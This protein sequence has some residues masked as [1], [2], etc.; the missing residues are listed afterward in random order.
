MKRK[1]KK[2]AWRKKWKLFQVVR[3]TY[4][5]PYTLGVITSID[6]ERE[7][8]MVRYIDGHFTK[9]VSPEVLK[10]EVVEPK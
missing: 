6:Y 3:S 2:R 7:L 1:S 9:W 10:I 8:I 5:K 4:Y